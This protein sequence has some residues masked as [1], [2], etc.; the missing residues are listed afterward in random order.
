MSI[1]RRIRRPAMTLIELLVVIG[2]IAVLIGL[3]LPAVQKVR[4]A[5]SRMACANNLCYRSASPS[6]CTTTLGTFPSNGGWDGQQFIYATDGSPTY[7]YT[8]NYGAPD[9]YYWGAGDPKR[10]G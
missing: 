9:P 4:E 5:A 10:T 1:L 8:D 2:I 6:R 7:V 3:L